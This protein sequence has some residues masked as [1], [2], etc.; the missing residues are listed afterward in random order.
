LAEPVER[1]PTIA[2]T[3]RPLEGS[4]GSQQAG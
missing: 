2:S 1:C 4:C 3:S